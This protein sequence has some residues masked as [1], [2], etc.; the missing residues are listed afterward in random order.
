M[1][2]TQ[3][4]EIVQSVLQ[5]ASPVF[6]TIPILAE[7]YPYIGLTHTIRRKA[8]RWHVRVSD[9]CQGA[10]RAL[11]EA[12]TWILAGKILRRLP[13]PEMQR[14]YNAYRSTAPIVAA[15]EQRR[16][17]RGRKRLRAADSSHHS[18][19]EVFGEANARYFNDQI[20]IRELSWGRRDSWGRLAHYDPVHQT[21]SVSPVLDSPEVPRSILAFVV[22]HEMLHVLFEG[23]GSARARR[24]SPEFRKAERAH[25]A[26]QRAKK[27][28]EQYCRDRGACR[29]GS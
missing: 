14:L 16:R 29:A 21:I 9:H 6:R 25:P 11:L 22:Y 20:E 23:E 5:T 1:N 3:L 10:P 7:F 2:D 17:T 8:E 19:A 24:H 27:F 12:V 13:P 18:L 4:Q 26:Y 28:L 15:V